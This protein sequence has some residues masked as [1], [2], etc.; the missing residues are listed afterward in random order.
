M[1]V[2][3]NLGPNRAR[4]VLIL[5]IILAVLLLLVTQFQTLVQNLYLRYIDY[6]WNSV[7]LTGFTQ[8]NQ[9]QDGFPDD[10]LPRTWNNGRA[11]FQNETNE[12][13]TGSF[14]VLVEKTSSGGVVA[15]TQNITVPEGA[16]D[17]TLQVF[18]KGDGGAAQIRYIFEGQTNAVNGGWQDIPP[19]ET[20]RN[21]QVTKQIPAEVQQIEVHF[22]SH[23]RTYFD[24]A[25]LEFGRTGLAGANLLNNPGFEVDGLNQDPFVWW[26]EHANLPEVDPIPETVLTGELPFLNILDMLNGRYNNI[27][28]RIEQ[29]TLPC[30]TTPEMTSWLLDLAPEIEEQGGASAREKLLQLA[31]ALAPSCPQPYGQLARLYEEN[32]VYYSAAQQYRRAAEIAGETPLAGYYYFN[33]GLIHVRQTG[34]LDQAI[35]TLEKA[36]TLEVWVTGIVFQGASAYN[37]GLAYKNAGL[38]EQAALSFQRVLDCDFCSYYRDGAEA[39]LAE[40]A[41]E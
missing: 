36:E 37:L 28:Q 30:A 21:Y 11:V 22:R 29:Q 31:I 18:A 1:T 4:W 38:P 10:W 19:Q 35:Y 2:L 26:Q 27:Q 6:K 8:N 3:Q 41:G 9:L 33:E 15:L 16:T 14:A 34:D 25:F 5:V 20:W 12:V 23:G 24:D 17:V 39:E 7:E 40:L 32:G 13:R